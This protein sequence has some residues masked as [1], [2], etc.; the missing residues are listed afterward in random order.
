MIIKDIKI[1]NFRSF[2]N[3]ISIKS[4]NSIAIL[5][6]ENNTGKSNILLALDHNECSPP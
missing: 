2:G 1:D 6:G 3:E 4:L 5:I